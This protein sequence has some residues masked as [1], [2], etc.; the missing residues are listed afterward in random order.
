MHNNLT[1]RA[2]PVCTETIYMQVKVE[3]GNDMHM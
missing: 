2:I 1:G 3:N